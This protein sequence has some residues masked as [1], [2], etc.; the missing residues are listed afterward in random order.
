MISPAALYPGMKVGVCGIACEKCPRMALGKCPNGV[1]GCV[2]RENKFCKLCACAI[3]KGVALCFE[4]AEFPCETT[5][6]GPV[7]H[8]YCQYISGKGG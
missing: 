4:C 1:R 6:E 5:G 3:N 2:P 7:S 8:G